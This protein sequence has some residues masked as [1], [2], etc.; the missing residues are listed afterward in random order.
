MLLNRKARFD[1]TILNSFEAGLVLLGG[2]VK[3]IRNG[4]GDIVRGHVMLH[5]NEAWLMNMFI[6]I[7]KNSTIEYDTT[8]NRKLLLKKKQIRSLIGK[9]KEKGLTLV[10]LKLYFVRGLAKIEIGI[11]EGKKKFDKRKTI[12]ERDLR[13]EVE[14]TKLKY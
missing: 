12:K 10:P 9:I 6:P 7:Y 5:D 3:A 14:R 8:R 4:M 1:Y 11:A 13:R 2:E